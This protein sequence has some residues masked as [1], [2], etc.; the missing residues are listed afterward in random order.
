MKLSPRQRE[1]ARIIAEGRFFPTFVKEDD[2]W[3]ARWRA[4]DIENDW[5]DEMVR[6]AAMTSL[7]EDAEDQKHETLHDAWMLALKS[8]TGLVIWDDGECA[9]F[10][11][12]LEEWSGNAKIDVEARK[13]IRFKFVP[14]EITCQVPTNRAGLKALGLSTY[15]FYPLRG[16]RRV[17][18]DASRLSVQL[19]QSEAENF[20]RHGAHD[21]VNAGYRVDG[22]DIKADV[23]AVADV[24]TGDAKKAHSLKV[25]LTVRV[26][27]EAVSAE[28]IRFLLEQGS[29]IVFF[30]NRW[31]EVD[32]SVLRE[33]LRAL[34]RGVGKKPNL[35]SFAL[36]IG[37]IGK[38]EIEAAKT[39]GWIRGL[40]NELTMMGREIPLDSF[41]AI[42]G[43][44]GSLREY[45]Q[46]GVVW[47][48]FL[49]D[50]GFGALLADDMGLGKTIQTIAWL[51]VSHSHALVVAPLTLLANW[52]HEIKNFAPKLKIYVH[53]GDHRH[54]AS[55][56]KRFANDADVVLTSY[57]LLV[58]DYQEFA[59]VA[60]D[61]LILDEAQMIKNVNTQAAKAV[62]SLSPKKR[63][64]LTG[65]PIENSVEDIWAIED[66]LNPGFLGDRKSFIERF[67]KPI[68]MNEHSNAGN[69]LRH[70]LEPFILRRLKSDPNIAAEIGDKRE[71]R[72]YCKLLP[73]ERK[74]YEM[75][76]EEFRQSERAQGDIFALITRLKLICDGESKLERLVELLGQIFESGESALIFTQ[77]AKVGS[78]LRSE[79]SK[80]FGRIFP[81]LN[82]ALS[83]K[84][85]VLEIEKF[86]HGNANAFILSL[87]AGG[88]GL[89]LTKATHVIHFDRWWNP[90]VEDQATDRAH[91]IGQHK[92]VFVHLFIMMGTL[93]ERVDEIL[94]RKESL[95]ALIADGDAF[96]N[97]VLL[98]K[99]S[100]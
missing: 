8:R 3:H 5:V 7:S 98:S 9:E 22:A 51:L 49:T 62:R 12:E 17:D 79:L 70:A 27:G 18:G 53:Q 93:E 33:A 48:K 24:E 57:N 73:N 4:I 30:R 15:V 65:T 36:G 2:G 85:R 67:V 26:A 25:K 89:N 1:A 72:E 55:G 84:E 31:I 47:L 56:F 97:A 50:N 37:R 42:S 95:K 6:S 69:R 45:Q 92:M 40:L 38:L 54:I 44:Q 80:R 16:M 88:F 87:R 90:A 11:K 66:F 58:H 32:R 43:L 13:G 29:T 52:E 75:A 96:Y 41:T 78:W 60:W 94:S 46:R 63:I 91:R 28:E 19:T 77:Y 81:Y 86:K 83:A 71:I 64:A 99:E 20:V 23:S 14:Y 59:E 74:D 39:H 100:K 21:L 10:A 61:A 34:E 76:L 35:I 82:G 68:A